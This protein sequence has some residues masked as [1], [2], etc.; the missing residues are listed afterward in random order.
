ML[1]FRSSGTT[2]AGTPPRKARLTVHAALS[3]S[4]RCLGVQ[5]ASA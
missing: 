3:Q 5:L 4:S 1:I 2:F